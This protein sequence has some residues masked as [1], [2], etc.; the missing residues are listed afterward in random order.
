MQESHSVRLVGLVVVS[1]FGPQPIIIRIE[2]NNIITIFSSE[3]EVGR[4][5]RVPTKTLT[6]G[7]SSPLQVASPD[8][9]NLNSAS[10]VDSS[11]IKAK[12]VSVSANWPD[13]AY[14]LKYI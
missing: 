2:I 11:T 10:L 13:K 7:L 5:G 4:G 8:W 1:L 9:A 6:S 3:N 14:T 12:T